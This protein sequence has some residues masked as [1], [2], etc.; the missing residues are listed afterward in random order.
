MVNEWRVFRFP[1]DDAL[2]YELRAVWDHRGQLGFTE[3][4][5]PRAYSR[6]ALRAEL[7]REHALQLAAFDK[8]TLIQIPSIIQDL[9]K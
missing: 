3:P 8:P 7:L 6:A 9:E 5:E 2:C 4:A 1:F